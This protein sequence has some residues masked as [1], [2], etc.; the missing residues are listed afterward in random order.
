MFWEKMIKMKTHFYQTSHW[1]QLLN[2]GLLSFGKS[3]YIHVT[4]AVVLTSNFQLIPV[5]KV[6][7]EA[8]IHIFLNWIKIIAVNLRMLWMMVWKIA[9]W[10]T[11]VILDIFVF[12]EAVNYWSTYRASTLR[13]RRQLVAKCIF[14]I[15]CP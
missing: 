13:K 15:Y 7:T 11:F 9:K 8:L 10:E 6:T 5:K 4:S 12:H 2:N 14:H 3:R 1:G